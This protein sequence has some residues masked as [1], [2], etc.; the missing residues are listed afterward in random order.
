M[1]ENIGE[2]ISNNVLGTRNVVAA[3]GTVGTKRLVLVSTDKAVAPTSVMG[4]S[5]RVAEMI[6]RDAARRENRAY[7]VVRFGN[8]L[9]SRGS[10]VPLFKAQIE[11][12]G[13]ITVTHPDVRRYFMTIPEAVH[14]VLQAGGLG[15][16]G[17]LFVLDMGEPV[18]LREMAADLVRLSGLESH[19]VPIIFTGLRPGEKLDEMLWEEGAEV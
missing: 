16:G 17:E 1:E 13:P 9:G 19:E 15:K 5:K 11:R 4:A 7:V 10:V 6:V 14:L 8:V 3:A 18:L 12:G 2:A